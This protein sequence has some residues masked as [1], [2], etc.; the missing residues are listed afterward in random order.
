MERTGEED[1]PREEE[2]A[3][4]KVGGW[5]HTSEGATLAVLC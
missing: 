4:R 3:S 2:E 1:D 5:K